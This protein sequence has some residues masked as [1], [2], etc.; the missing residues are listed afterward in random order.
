M[1]RSKNKK[2][3]RRK[4]SI[5]KISCRNRRSRKDGVTKKEKEAIYTL[6]NMSLID[7]EQTKPSAG[8][9]KDFAP[10]DAS[11]LF[12]YTSKYFPVPDKRTSKPVVKYV[13]TK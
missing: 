4:K 9:I 11:S 2:S 1:K 5:K 3:M 7:K 10:S 8:S 12:E 6:T 13:P